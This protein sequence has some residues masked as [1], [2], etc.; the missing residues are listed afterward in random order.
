[1]RQVGR[2]KKCFEEDPKYLEIFGMWWWSRMGKIGGTDRVRNEEALQ[3]VNEER[4]ILHAMK[5]I[6]G[7]WIGHILGRNCLLKYVIEGKLEERIKATGRRRRRRK[8]VLDD[9]KEGREQCKLKEE[10]LDGSV[11]RNRSLRG[12]RPVARQIT[13]RKNE[14]MQYAA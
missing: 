2:I 7:K 14:C 4:N 5:R 10:T 8:R 13:I 3:T 11:C 12:Y 1:V 9:L 6:E